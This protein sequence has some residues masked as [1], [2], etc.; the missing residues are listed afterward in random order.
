MY[1]CVYNIYIICIYIIYSMYIHIYIYIHS[2]VI[3]SLQLDQIYNRKKL[4]HIFT[5]RFELL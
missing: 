1:V 3:S 5:G 2:R 4:H